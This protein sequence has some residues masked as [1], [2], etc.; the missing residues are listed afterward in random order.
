M[1][2][3]ALL[4]MIAGACPDRTAA[5]CDGR[6]FTFLELQRLSSRGS[7]LLRKMGANKLV[8]LG[9]G[10]ER[11]AV[12]LFAAA[13]AGISYAPLNYRLSSA[14]LNALVDRL[15]PALLVVDPQFCSLITPRDQLQIMSADELV[16]RFRGFD[17][18]PRSEPA[19]SSE[20][21]VL[22]F[23]SG[24][25]GAPK[26]AILRHEN[27]V[28]YV[29]GSVEFSCAQGDETSLIAVPPYHIAGVTA[30]LTGTYSGQRLDRYL[31]PICGHAC[32][33]G[34]DD[35]RAHRGHIGIE[36]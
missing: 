18:E 26:M 34:S 31:S 7:G 19:A 10:S 30:L 25:T 32:L 5:V 3:F 22:I 14:E 8:R 11:E 29:A 1:S 33:C 20:P 35:A 4:E 36:W 9:V 6:S 2:I 21:A 23:S 24:T 13:G 16:V 27:L 17:D 28:S 12:Y 15:I